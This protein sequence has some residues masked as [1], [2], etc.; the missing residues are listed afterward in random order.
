MAVSSGTKLGPYE[1]QSP[2]GAGGM[3]EVYRARDTRL[4]RTVAVKILPAHL[5]ESS[6]ARQ[7]FEREARAISSLSHP[8][9]CRLYDIGQQDGTSYLVMEYLEGETLADR[10]MKGKLP[11]DQ[12]LRIGIEIGQALDMAHRGGIVHRDLKPG[13]IILTR[14]G[15]KL[16]DFGLAKPTTAAF[17]SDVITLTSHQPLTGQGTLVGTFQYMAPEQ[18]EAREADARSDIFALGAVL[19]EMVTGRRAFEG[20]SQISVLAAILEK[21]PAPIS[22]LEPTSPLALDRIIRTCLAKNPDERFQS[23]QDIAL[24]LKWI[25]EG[26][27]VAAARSIPAKNRWLPWGLAAAG[28]LATIILALLYVG[29]RSQPEVVVRSSILPPQKSKFTLLGSEAG[30]VV[31][32]PDGRRI[33]FS[34]PDQQGKTVLWVR[35]LDSLSAQPLVGTQSAS[36]PFWSPDS[37]YLGFFAD[38]K[39]KKINASG[40]PPQT[41]ADAQSGRGGTWGARGDI[42]FAPSP[43][44]PIQRVSA[45]GG[46]PVDIMD[47]PSQFLSLRWPYFLPDGRHFVYFD[48]NLTDPKQTGIYVAQLDT[49]DRKFLL[50]TD[51]NAIYAAPG[52][53]LYLRG[54]LLFAQPFDVRRLRLTGDAKLI[55]ER[56]GE[57]FTVAHGAFSASQNGV[58]VFEHSEAVSGGDS[59]VWLDAGGKQLATVAQGEQYSWQRISPDGKLLAVQIGTPTA[60]GALGGT[61]DIWIMDLQRGTRSR[62]TFGSG[63]SFSPLWSPDGTKIY[64]SAIRT[65]LPHIYAK[66]ANGTGEEELIYDGGT[67]ER[68]RSISSDGRYLIFERLD[69]VAKTKQDVWALPLFGDR[70]PFPLVNT[71]FSDV[72]PSI[73]PDGKWVAYASNESAKFEVYLTSFPVPASRLQVSTAGGQSPRWRRDGKKLFFVSDDR[74]IMAVDVSARGGS[75]VLGEPRAVAALTVNDAS[76]GLS[77][78]GPIEVAPDGKRLLVTMTES[79]SNS[80]QPAT[81]VINWPAEL[82]K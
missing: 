10:L 72:Q 32:S 67:D 37:Q 9:I 26:N 54:D 39:L 8:H 34:A 82:N 19:Y 17:S 59:L 47:S 35:A 53:L 41:L 5:S 23:A 18:L 29:A 62:L 50:Q 6:D 57:N 7:R 15:A 71:Q 58:L 14:S 3:G 81:L 64:Y 27:E 16:T 61:T 75:L 77:S 65:G 55:D 11:A 60:A 1:I 36:Y 40:G 28:V 56:V 78:F 76:S 48:R 12:V 79:S 49:K 25:A 13:N 43:N 63:I 52:Y 4:D 33:A 24:Q 42:V 38:G 2:L 44:S 68:V 46:I 20:K 45:S 30:P 66:P 21:E 73:S 31:V 70:K 22:S 69:G 74:H 80:V 51:S